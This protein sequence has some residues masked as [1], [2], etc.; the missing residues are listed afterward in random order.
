MTGRPPKSSNVKAAAGNPGGRPVNTPPEPTTGRPGM[1]V[2]LS[3]AGKKEWRRIVPELEDMGILTVVDGPILGLWCEAVADVERATFEIDRDGMTFKNPE[4]GL[5]KAHPAVAMRKAAQAT[6]QKIA[7]DYGLTPAARTRI[8]V[9][10]K[11]T[12]SKL[13]QLLNRRKQNP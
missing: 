9:Q 7:N 4:S 3:K 5:I 11:Q 1:P 6:M 13:Q 8:H 12:G 10:K 2:G